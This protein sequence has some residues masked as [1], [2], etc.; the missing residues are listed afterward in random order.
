MKYLRFLL[1]PFARVYG[2]I[3][4]IRNILFASGFLERK[5]YK[6]P[7]FGVGNLSMGGTGKSVV[8]DY[9]INTLK[10][11]YKTGTLSRGYGRSSKGFVLATSNATAENIGDEPY[12]YYKKH[13]EITVSVS[14]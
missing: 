13:P 1:A 12:Q 11:K 8:I 10:R 14:E 3:M 4:S 7:T 5:Q 9:L 2:L 6:T